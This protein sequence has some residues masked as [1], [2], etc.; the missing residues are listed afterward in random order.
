MRS[1]EVRQKL[2]D[3][4]DEALYIYSRIGTYWFYNTLYL[5]VII[6]YIVGGNKL[7][8]TS[9]LYT[10]IH[11]IELSVLPKDNIILL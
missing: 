3:L 7:E 5:D 10:C 1:P 9:T 6:I 2:N 4:T 11:L 8:F